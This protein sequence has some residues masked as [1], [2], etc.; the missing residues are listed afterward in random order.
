M[1]KISTLIALFG[2]L[3]VGCT[4]ETA[5]DENGTGGSTVIEDAQVYL[6]LGLVAPG[7]GTRAGE[8]P[9]PNPG[10]YEDGVNKETAVETIRF[11]FFDDEGQPAGVRKNPAKQGEFFSYYDFNKDLDYREDGNGEPNITVEKTV[12]IDL[13]LNVPKNSAGEIIY[14]K[15]VVAVINPNAAALVDNPTMNLPA[16]VTSTTPEALTAIVS[17]FDPKEKSKN[18]PFKYSKIGDDGQFVMSNSVYLESDK[19]KINWTKLNE[20]TVAE[21]GSAEKKET[22]VTVFETVEEAHEFKTTIFVERVTAR[23]DLTV[24]SSAATKYQL[25]PATNEDGESVAITKYVDKDGKEVTLDAAAAIKYTGT[26]YD[27][28]HPKNIGEGM[29]NVFFTGTFHKLNQPDAVA[30]PIFVKFYGWT[31][32][33][34][35]KRSNLLKNIDD[36]NWVDGL[37]QKNNEPW[38]IPGYHRS[39]WAINPDLKTAYTGEVKVGEDPKDYYF[40]AYDDIKD[41]NNF[42]GKKLGGADGKTEVDDNQYAGSIYIQENAAKYYAANATSDYTVAKNHE[43]KVIVAAELLNAAGEPMTIVEYGLR[44]YEKDG[45]LEILAPAISKYL[46][47]D[48]EDKDN[49]GLEAT[50]LTY[51]TY[52]QH[53]NETGANVKGGYLAYITLTDAAAKETWYTIDEDGEVKKDANG[54]PKKLTAA[55]AKKIIDDAVNESRLLVWEGGQTYYYF[56]IRH[57]GK[58][59]DNDNTDT[60]ED[61]TPVPGRYGVVRN[62]IYKA[63]ISGLFGLGTPVL[64]S[65]EI[66]Y[67]EKPEHSDYILATEIKVLQWRV[68]KEDYEFS[69]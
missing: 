26:G 13:L 60:A 34:T 43:S 23:L 10:D 21:A 29:K 33:S 49:S 19:E 51:E 18:E 66:I 64:D 5:L 4:K 59:P 39:F 44:Y 6:S 16:S 15:Y 52:A 47:T 62:H 8:T 22:G 27:A 36:T 45:L 32:V 25:I 56:P 61:A 55:E 2:L 11:Y 67:P 48:P 69:W 9:T 37:F 30:E 41:L 38:N 31:V 63:D 14:P 17:D 46:F 50:D 57:L 68:V 65:D 24:G 7:G 35:P 40:Y 53:F 1:K 12:N 42:Y 58:Q 28:K 54:Q 3:A 20:Q